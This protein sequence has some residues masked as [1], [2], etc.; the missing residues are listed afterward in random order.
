[1]EFVVPP[2]GCDRRG[3]PGQQPRRDHRCPAEPPGEGA[4]ALGDAVAVDVLDS[5]QAA[6]HLCEDFAERGDQIATQNDRAQAMDPDEE[7]HRIPVGVEHI[8]PVEPFAL[9]I[10]T[11]QMIDHGGRSVDEPA[12]QFSQPEGKVALLPDAGAGVATVDTADLLDRAAPKGHVRSEKVIDLDVL[13]RIR[14]EVPGEAPVGQQQAD[15]AEA[16]RALTG[17][18][19]EGGAAHAGDVPILVAGQQLLQPIGVGVRVVVEEGDDLLG[20]QGIADGS[21]FGG[22]PTAQRAAHIDDV[23]ELAHQSLGAGVRGAVDDDD[24]V[25]QHRLPPQVGQ[26]VNDS[27]RPVEGDD[28]HSDRRAC[29]GLGWHGAPSCRSQRRHMRRRYRLATHPGALG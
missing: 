12:T 24:P 25:R 6:A 10:D 28:D 19:V 14:G 18:P 20:G 7:D 22:V 27:I 3:N 5:G 16:V 26:A 11:G 29:P 4:E 9:G 13:A 1:M 15:R 21:G 2:A 23:G 17:D 8:P